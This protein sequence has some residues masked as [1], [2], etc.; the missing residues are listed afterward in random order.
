MRYEPGFLRSIFHYFIPGVLTYSAIFSPLP[1]HEHTSPIPH[2]SVV[3]LVLSCEGRS[4]YLEPTSMEAL[5][6]PCSPTAAPLNYCCCCYHCR[7]RNESNK[8]E[9]ICLSLSFA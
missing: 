5:G 3:R 6:E 9:V 2:W 4:F 7:A 1:F 8:I